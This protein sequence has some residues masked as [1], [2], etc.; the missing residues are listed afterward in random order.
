MSLKL[1]CVLAHPDDESL[2]NGGMLARYAAE[3]VET[4]LVCATRGERGWMQD[5]AT[6]PG[7]AALGEIREGE[8]RAAGAVLG[9][10]EIEFLDYIDGDLDQA[11]PSEAIAKIAA[12]IRRIRPHVVVTFGPD[13]GYGHPDHIAISQFTTAACVCAADPSYSGDGAGDGHRVAKLYYM[14][15][16]PDL[17]AAYVTAFGEIS[18]AVDG[19]VRQPQACPDWQVTT[20]IEALAYVAQAWQAVLCHRTQLP[21]YHILAAVPQDVRNSI[22]GD[23]AY[24]RAYS[25]VNGGRRIERDLFDGLR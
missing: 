5:A 4:Y 25:M 7:P 20:R 10:R 24:Y 19:M 22:W 3:G 23:T 16:P 11:A 1:L 6:Y 17:A 14:A 9:L 18:I 8:L 15:V 21:A 2:G 12:A 13:G